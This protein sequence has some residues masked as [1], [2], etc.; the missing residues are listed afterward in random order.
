MFY[1]PF[2]RCT[3]LVPALLLSAMT[4]PAFA[5]TGSTEAVTVIPPFLAGLVIGTSGLF[6][7]RYSV[8]K[9]IAGLIAHISAKMSGDLKLNE[10]SGISGDA[11]IGALGRVLDQFTHKISDQAKSFEGH[12]NTILCSSNTMQSLAGDMLNKCETTKGNTHALSSESGQVN[13][14]MSSVAAAVEQANTSIDLVAAASEEMH[15]T[16]QEITK[17]MS[18]ARQTTKEA[19]GI[20]DQVTSGMD[21]L[22]QAAKS[23]SDITEAISEISE[24]TNLLALNATIE[25]ARAGEA[26]KGF[27]VVANEIKTLAEETGSATLKIKEMVTAIT[28]LTQTSQTDITEV[29]QIIS[30]MDDA[31]TSIAAALEEQSVATREISQNAHQAAQGIGNIQENMVSTT[32]EVGHM[33]CQIQGICDDAEGIGM[34]IFETR[35]NAEEATGMSEIMLAA[36]KAFKTDPPAFDIGNVKVA[37]MGWRTTLEAVLAGHKQM[38]PEEVVSHRDCAFGKWYFSDGKKFNSLDL[39]RQIGE[40]HETVHDQARAVIKSKNAGDTAGAKTQMEKFIAAKDAM[41]DGLDR[42]YRM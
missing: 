4:C 33:D 37:H 14:N 41:F 18:E 8:T 19:V 31:V 17:S 1:R 29:S 42:L 11:G 6:Y 9:K 15:A 30:K 10:D 34:H 32:Q 7:Y 27:A 21:E 20:S 24:Q 38:K 23:I 35:I 22:G 40:F 12:A 25:S 28:S 2:L 36:A 5:Q 39:Y 26:G 3:I 16:I 13:G